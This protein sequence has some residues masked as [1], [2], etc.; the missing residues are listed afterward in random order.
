VDD[1]GRGCQRPNALGRVDVVLEP[2][3]GDDEKQPSVLEMEHQRIEGLIY[4]RVEDIDTFVVCS[5]AR[6]AASTLTSSL[7]L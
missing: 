1:R 4:A 2:R 5:D 3:N 7:D 6:R